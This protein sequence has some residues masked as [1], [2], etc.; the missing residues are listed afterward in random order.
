MTKRN[1]AYTIERFR[2]VIDTPYTQVNGIE[3]A[4]ITSCV[5]SKNLL[6][7]CRQHIVD[8]KIMTELGRECITSFFNDFIKSNDLVFNSKNKPF[9]INYNGQDVQVYVLKEYEEDV[10]ELT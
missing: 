10:K 5:D 1:F 9:L 4:N 8:I 7:L 2:N 3:Y 6:L